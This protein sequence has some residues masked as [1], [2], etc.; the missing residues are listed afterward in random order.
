[1]TRPKPVVYEHPTLT[2]DVAAPGATHLEIGHSPACVK[3]Y[4]S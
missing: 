1:M 3:I 4:R 2:A